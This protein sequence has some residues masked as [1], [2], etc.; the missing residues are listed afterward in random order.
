MVIAGIVAGGSGSR[1]GQTDT[2]KQFLLL[3]KK[4]IIVHTIEKFLVNSKIDCVV[5]GVHKDWFQYMCDLKE[6]FF[7]KSNVLITEGGETRNDTIKNIIDLSY[8]KLGCCNDDIIVTHD[9]VRP[10]VSH[11]IINDN[12]KATVEFGICD[13]VIVATDT[14]VRSS[15]NDVITDIPARNEMYQGQTPQSFK[16]GMFN[17]VFNDLSNEEK[18][19]VTDACKLFFLKGYDVKLVEGDVCN[20]KITYP[21]DYKVAKIMMEN[22][23]DD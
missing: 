13:T 8:Q 19:I 23:S 5:V 2:P 10:F 21:F 1:M 18:S 20:I 4:P 17:Q 12:V 16:M 6:K 3:D 11:K 14:I 15:D 7:G 22:F 9:A